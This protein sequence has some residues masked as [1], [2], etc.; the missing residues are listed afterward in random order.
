MKQYR[1]YITG[2]NYLHFPVVISAANAGMA[3]IIARQQYP[4]AKGIGCA[5]EIR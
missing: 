2:A 1:I 4:D 3:Q 5:V